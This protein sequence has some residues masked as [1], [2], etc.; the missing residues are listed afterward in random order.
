MVQ[1]LTKEQ[2]IERATSIHGD[3][4]DLSQVVYVDTS[5]HVTVICAKHGPWSVTPSNLMSGFGCRGCGVERRTD[6][7]RITVP[8]FLERSREAHGD[9][10]DYS[11][12][13]VL[14]GVNE[15]VEIVCTIHGPWATVPKTHMAGS[16]CPPCSYFER[17][18]RRRRPVDDFIEAATTLHG[19][20]YSY[21]LVDFV[22]MKTKVTVTCLAH[23]QWA[24]RPLSHLRG[25]GCPNCGKRSASEKTRQSG[26][27]FVTRARAVHGER[28]GYTYVHYTRSSEKVQIECP[29]HGPFWQTPNN[30]LNGSGWDCPGFG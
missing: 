9:R 24:V 2:F 5:T 29:S 6:G 17:S 3:K 11:R 7:R 14:N 15:K 1:R 10:Y 25:D 12:I 26:N 13:V 21:T 30:H 8:E 4:Y 20:R 16:G 22:D 28:Y 19:G 23:G 18:I 27:E